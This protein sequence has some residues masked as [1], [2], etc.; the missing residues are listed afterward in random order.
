MRGGQRSD[1]DAVSEKHTA[2]AG[3]LVTIQ[4]LVV[5]PCLS[6]LFTSHGSPTEPDSKIERTFLYI[7]K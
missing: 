4:Q 6:V 1:A 2:A 7:K 3:S 5:A